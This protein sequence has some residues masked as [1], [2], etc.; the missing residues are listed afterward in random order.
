MKKI[1][2]AALCFL[3]AVIS[4]EEK[5]IAFAGSTR[6][7]SHNK[8]LAQ[9]AA[10][11][12]RDRGAQVT[13]IDLRDYPM[14]FYDADLESASGLPENAK[15][16]RDLL[17]QADGAIIATPEYNGSLPAVLKNAIDWASRSEEKRPSLDAFK[18]KKFIILSASPGPRGGVDAA[19]HLTFILKRLGGKVMGDPLSFGSQPKDFTPE[20]HDTVAQLTNN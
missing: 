20:L 19:A 11:I 12:A 16:F 5:F 14:P 6:N 15:K 13:F 10:K 2:L 4:A 7:D 18:G 1:F 8:K 3:S 9:Q 17:L